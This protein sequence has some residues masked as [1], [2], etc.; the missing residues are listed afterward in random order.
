MQAFWLGD[1]FDKML[2]ATS[3]PNLWLQRVA[4]SSESTSSV[5]ARVR[6]SSEEYSIKR[7]RIELPL[8]I[9]AKEHGHRA[10]SSSAIKAAS[11]VPRERTTCSS[12]RLAEEE[13]AASATIPLRVCAM[14]R[15][16]AVRAPSK[17]RKTKREPRA[18]KA[19]VRTEQR[20]C[21]SAAAATVPP[22]SR[23]VAKPTARRCT[24]DATSTEAHAVAHPSSSSSAAGQL[25]GRLPSVATSVL[26]AL[27]RRSPHASTASSSTTQMKVFLTIREAG[28]VGVGAPRPPGSMWGRCAA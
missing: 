21:W 10:S 22:A 20:I 26:R 24:S 11:P 13:H 9:K 5:S 8:A 23:S 28:M 19:S 7:Q 16:S 2:K 6:A 14:V 25:R 12:T 15:A 4:T 3:W 18:S 27:L 1:P 17:A